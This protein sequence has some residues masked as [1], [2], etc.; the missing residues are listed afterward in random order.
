MRAEKTLEHETIARAGRDLVALSQF[1]A[2][3]FLDHHG[4][5]VHQY[6]LPGDAVTADGTRHYFRFLEVGA[7]EAVRY[8]LKFSF[9]QVILN[10]LRSIAPTQDRASILDI[11]SNIGETYALLKELLHYEPDGPTLEFVGL[12]ISENCVAFARD[13]FLGDPSFQSVQGEASDLSRFPDR[14]FDFAISNGVHNHVVDQGRAVREA[15]RVSRIAAYFQINLSTTGK[16]EEYAN[17]S[18]PEFGYKVPTLDEF[19][20]YFPDAEHYHWYLPT[21]YSR[22][23]VQNDDNRYIDLDDPTKISWHSLI[24]SRYPIFNGA[25]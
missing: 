3:R 23:T 11:G 7:H 15:L 20:A 6:D 4:V 2:I 8:S 12:D 21:R 9:T 13:L 16:T 10:L 25:N 24:V 18:A 19:I 5:P 22:K 17:S 1:N 14:T